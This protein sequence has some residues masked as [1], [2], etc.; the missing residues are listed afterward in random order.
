MLSEHIYCGRWH[1]PFRLKYY[2]N[3]EWN[4]W[5]LH[6]QNG[7]KNFFFVFQFSKQTVLDS[8]ISFV[9]NYEKSGS[10]IENDLLTKSSVSK[11]IE[12]SFS[13][14]IKEIFVFNFTEIKDSL[15]VTLNKISIFLYQYNFYHNF[16]ILQFCSTKYL[17]LTLTF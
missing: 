7:E 5:K 9:E 16:L 15:F 17:F 11:F 14:L 3:H 1:C 10:V 6:L 2:W 13:F 8:Y 12:V 4:K